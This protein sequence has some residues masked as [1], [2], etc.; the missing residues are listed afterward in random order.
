[1][2]E[3]QQLEHFEIVENALP[4]LWTRARFK[5]IEGDEVNRAA[6]HLFQGVR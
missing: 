2:A 4:Q 1:M 6:Q 5:G 3:Y